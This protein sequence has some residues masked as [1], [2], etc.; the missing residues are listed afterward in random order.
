MIPMPSLRSLSRL[1]PAL[2]LVPLAGGLV[3][4]A[5]MFQLVSSNVLAVN[6]TTANQEFKLYSNYLQGAQAAG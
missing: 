5:A 4:L 2:A 1:L 6:S 3:A